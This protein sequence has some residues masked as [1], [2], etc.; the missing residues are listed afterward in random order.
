MKTTPGLFL[1][2]P[3]EK[4]S[5]HDEPR[6]G[7]CL[8]EGFEQASPR[9][10]RGG[11]DHEPRASATIVAAT[12]MLC[13]RLPLP[14]NTAL[15][16]TAGSA[17]VV[18]R[19]D[20]RLFPRARSAQAR[21]MFGMSLDLDGSSVDG[22][23]QLSH[24]EA[25]AI[26][27]RR[28]GNGNTRSPRCRRLVVRQNLL[29]GWSATASDRDDTERRHPDEVTARGPDG[30]DEDVGDVVGVRHTRPHR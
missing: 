8:E 11:L 24:A 16:H 17:R 28:I 23:Q 12:Q 13:Q 6:F 5:V 21:R 30:G 7:M 22:L 9:G 20:R 26:E 3:F 2:L 27:R 15:G 19:C 4:R 14:R 29:A 1:A 10:G 18:E 25:I